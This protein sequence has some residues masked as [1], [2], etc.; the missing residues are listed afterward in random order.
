MKVGGLKFEVVGKCERD[1]DLKSGV[2]F[3][4]KRWKDERV[5]YAFRVGRTVKYIGV[6]DSS[7]TTLKKRMGRYQ[8]MTGAGTNARITGNIDRALGARRKV[9]ILA[10]KPTR[11]FRVDGLKIDV[12]KAVE[13][14]LI[15]KVKPDWNIKG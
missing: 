3:R 4:V 6:C 1:R 12:V 11:V 15:A 7:G 9:E 8:G 14:P 13:N 5:V 10:W 2:R